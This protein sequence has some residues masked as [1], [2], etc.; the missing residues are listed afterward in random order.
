MKLTNFS[1][2]VS[3]YKENFLLRKKRFF[4]EKKQIGD[5]KRKEREENIETVKA[6]EPLI[7]TSTG[8]RTKPNNF[9]DGIYR[10]LG[11]ALA[12]LVLSNLDS[13]I[14]IASEIYKKIKELKKGIENFVT[15]IQDTIDSFYSGF[16]SFKQDLDDL[17][18]PFTNADLSVIDPF[19]EQ[20]EAVLF[21]TLGVVDNLFKKTPDGSPSPKSSPQPPQ[22]STPRPISRFRAPG[23][24]LA[25]RTFQEN[26]NRQILTRQRMLSPSGPTGP[27]GRLNMMRRGL[28]ASLETG[29]AFRGLGSGAQRGAV[30]T[31][32]QIKNLKNIG[33]IGGRGLGGRIPIIGPLLLGYDAY[34]EDLDGDGN[35]D[36]NIDK[37][38]FVAGGAAIGGFLGTFIPIPVLGSILGTSIGGYVG[39]LFYTLLKGGGAKEVGRKLKQDVLK[40]ID[41]G[42]LVKDWILR[43]IGNIQNQD[44]GILGN[45]PIGIP[46]T[47]MKFK[48]G[49]W[50]EILNPLGDPFKKLSILKK[51]FF[52]GQ[53]VGD[54]TVTA[55]KGDDSSDD[56]SSDDDFPDGRR[57]IGSQNIIPN[58]AEEIRI[59]AALST[60]AGRGKS[61]TD[62]L[63]V[64]ANRKAS[65]YKGYKGDN[66]F[67]GLLAAD[68]QFQGVYDKGQDAFVK[69]QTLADAARWAGTTEQVIKGYIADIRDRGYRSDSARFVK[70]AVQFRG[71]P[72]TVLK[73]NSDN[74]PNNDIIADAKGR[75]PNSAWRGGSG[76]NQFFTTPGDQG[77][78]TKASPILYKGVSTTLNRN[79]NENNTKTTYAILC[80]GT[81]DWSLSQSKITEKANKMIRDLINAGYKVVVVLPNK[82]L[83]VN[84]KK[85]P[86]PHKGVH[87]AAFG[88]SGVIIEK[89]KYN[90]SKDSSHLDPIEA[91]RIRNKYKPAIYVGDSN[92]V[93]IAG[94]VKEAKAQ[95]KGKSI[96]TSVEG[97]GG[98]KIQALINDIISS[99]PT[100][101]P[102]RLTVP[103]EE[104]PRNLTNEDGTPTSEGK[105]YLRR[106]DA[107]EFTGKLISTGG[108]NED[109]TYSSGGFALRR[110]VNNMILP[111]RVA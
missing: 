57:N 10:F 42:N 88:Y 22:P 15:S 97:Y 76:D 92:A 12:G 37:S 54:S 67:T 95:I 83:M 81:N 70:G 64:V 29:T 78:G 49:G 72:T 102:T 24:S 17:L 45:I 60:E 86:N 99:S 87:S 98:D 19:K 107:G 84:G 65:G 79:R 74:N 46:F 62:V 9:L 110:E 18:S 96:T 2:V 21:A 41:A 34:M 71:S 51:S 108:L 38:L 61:A 47:N 28:G 104:I 6:V 66:S 26:L 93:R 106:L 75:I 48:L 101:T 111:V 40:I 53:N 82:D 11:F 56:Y 69:I 30:R 32:R 55:F 7:K 77:A 58:S 94:K 59:A 4:D 100:I 16:E 43:G 89:G 33:R 50:A 63:Q 3:T 23:Q 25:G 35:P 8:K 80:Y 14:S 5:E 90:N 105:E 52:S 13:I 103:L 109:T 44:G 27:L 68:N 39:D 36:R 20:L 91:D 31:F 1:S 85:Y 73:V